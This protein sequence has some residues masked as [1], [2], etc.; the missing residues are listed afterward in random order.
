L[1]V[2]LTG[3]WWLDELGEKGEHRIE[4]WLSIAALGLI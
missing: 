2:V 4:V 1:I 3:F